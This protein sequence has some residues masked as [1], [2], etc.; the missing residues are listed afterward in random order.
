[1]IR[2]HVGGSTMDYV[3]LGRTGIKV[4]R[5]CLGCMTYGSSQW[6]PWVL[7]EEASRPFFRRA[8]EAGVNFFDTADLYSNGASEAVL[9]RALRELAI[10]REQVVVA[11]KL[12][13]A[14]GQ[15]ANERG[16]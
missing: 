14:T 5:L 10:P 3:N 16:L 12:F 7:D 2:A 1:M 13:Y 15:S 9:G 8:W 4:S 6:R 11:T